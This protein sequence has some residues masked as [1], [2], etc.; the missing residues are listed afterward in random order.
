MLKNAE[1]HGKKW[2]TRFLKFY[3]KREAKNRRKLLKAK[4]A[5]DV[6]NVVELLETQEAKE[7]EMLNQ[8]NKME[9]AMNSVIDKKVNKNAKSEEGDF[10]EVDGSLVYLDIDP[11]D[12]RHCPKAGS[13]RN[14]VMY[15]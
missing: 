2:V 10:I 4:N 3:K 8:L 12:I 7:L 6:S 9:E 15:N 1:K 14:Y 13:W 11:I 5:G